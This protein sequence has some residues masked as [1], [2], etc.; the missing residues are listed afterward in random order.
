MDNA[1]QKQGQSGL[2]R[3]GS[4][5]QRKSI[6]TSQDELVKEGFLPAFS[7]LPLL[8]QPVVEGVALVE[9]ARQHKELIEKRLYTYGALLFRNFE[10]AS[11]EDF[12]QFIEVI[13]KQVMEYHEGASPRTRVSE[14]IY[15]STDYPP[16]HSI[17]LHNELSYRYEFPAKI[18][19]YCVRP[20]AERGETPIADVRKVLQRL[21]PKLCARFAREGWMLVRNYGD[22][23]GL[24]WQSVF[25]TEEKAAVEA[26]CQEAGVNFEWKGENRLRISQVRPALARHP[27]TGE[28]LWFN[29]AAFFHVSTLAPTI[30]DA[31]LAEFQGRDL[32]TNTY[33]G[34][35]DPIESDV[36]EALRNAYHQETVAFPWREKD[37]LLLDNMLIA[38]GRS[39]YSG[40]RKILV[41]MSDPVA[42]R[43]LPAL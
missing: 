30:R 17:F 27:H 25:H 43:D 12:Q 22:G 28:I 10:V 37:V 36:L 2:K 6:H 11:L 39:P 42:W 29:H 20:A 3:L 1:E 32:P 8:F 34:N 21:D 9:W 7:G 23:F 4:L 26:Y 24:P 41:G 38:H 18:F 35:G 16:E 19:F 5:H 33:Y 15:T 13:S 31:L 40:S 14:N